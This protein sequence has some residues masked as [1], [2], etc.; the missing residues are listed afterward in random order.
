MDKMLIA[1]RRGTRRRNMVKMSLATENGRLNEAESSKPSLVGQVAQ[2]L[3]VILI[4]YI[5][6]IYTTARQQSNVVPLRQTS[7]DAVRPTVGQLAR[8]SVSLKL[9]CTVEQNNLQSRPVQSNLL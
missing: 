5:H 3:E 6:K 4:K 2:A 1:I 8:L 9:I 7:S